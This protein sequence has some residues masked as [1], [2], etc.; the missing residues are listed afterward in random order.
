MEHTKITK[1]SVVSVASSTNIKDV[2]R[3]DINFYAKN[4]K[5]IWKD[6]AI[7]EVKN[8]RKIEVGEQRD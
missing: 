5:E 7:V 2:S 3:V 4:P 8:G 6:L 1:G